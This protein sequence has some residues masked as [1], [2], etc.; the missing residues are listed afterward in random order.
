MP[1]SPSRAP[2]SGLIGML[3]AMLGQTVGFPVPEGGAGRLAQALVDRFTAKRRHPAPRRTRASSA[4]APTGD[5]WSA[6]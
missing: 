6:C 4:F 3:L 1:T 2:G 5:A